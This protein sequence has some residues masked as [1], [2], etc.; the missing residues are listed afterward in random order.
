MKNE[1]DLIQELMQE[2]QDK[3]KYGKADVEERLSRHREPT[4]EVMKV[5]GDMP[6]PEKEEMHGEDPLMEEDEM[7]DDMGMD[8]DEEQ[9]PADKLKSRLM[10]LRG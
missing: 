6:M 3:M 9:S 4:V 5:E 2:L 7:V 10:K 1:L 8:E